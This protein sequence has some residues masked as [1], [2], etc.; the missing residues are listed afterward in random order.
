M[1][2]KCCFTVYVI[3]NCNLRLGV[4][5]TKKLLVLLFKHLQLMNYQEEPL[6]IQQCA[7]SKVTISFVQSWD[8][9]L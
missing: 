9:K 4:E 1:S 3:T 7:Q 6:L 8:G 5:D 2:Q